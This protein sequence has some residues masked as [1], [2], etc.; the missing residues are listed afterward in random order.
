[1][2]SEPPWVGRS[3]SEAGG[4]EEEEGEVERSEDGRVRGGQLAVQFS[5][6][7]TL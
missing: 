3:P 7:Q 5:H 4:E 2:S 6:Q 1:M